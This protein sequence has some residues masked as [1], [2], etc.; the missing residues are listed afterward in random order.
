MLE[1]THA[2]GTLTLSEGEIDLADGRPVAAWHAGTIGRAALDALRASD[3]AAFT[4]AARP[5]RP[6]NIEAE[7]EPQGVR[8]SLSMLVGRTVPRLDLVTREQLLR[9]AAF[10]M[11]AP[12]LLD[13]PAAAANV[14][15]PVALAALVNALIAEYAGATYG[16]II[17]NDDVAARLAAAGPPLAS[18]LAIAQGRIDLGAVQD[19]TDLNDVVPVLRSLLRAV[20]GEAVRTTGDGAARRGYRAAV[21]KQWGGQERVMSAATQIVEERP[22]GDAVLVVTKGLTGSFRLVDRE[23]TVGRASAGDI[24]LPHPSVSRR[25][26][27]I[28][29]R[30][31]A[32]VVS[33]LISTSGTVVNG[34]KISAERALR[35]GDL[36]GLGDVELRYERA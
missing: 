16:G 3:P 34:A 4:F 27:R 31:G 28:V 5:A 32:H 20:H 26:A 19:R 21:T 14:W 36:I 10:G 15:K 22:P 2:T 8:A 17:W 30:G 24:F 6:T 9:R 29:P 11:K 25:H 12:T 35:Q 33:D 13:E 23:Y 1:S 18:P 7:P